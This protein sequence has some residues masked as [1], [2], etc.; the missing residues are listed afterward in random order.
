MSLHRRSIVLATALRSTFFHPHSLKNMHTSIHRPALSR[1]TAWLSGALLAGCANMSAT[2]QGTA[3]GA[4]IGAVAG[5]I[6]SAATGGDAATGAVLGGAAGALGGNIW[7]RR[8]EEK[9]RAME[10]AT[11][12]SGVQ[13]TRTADDQLKLQVPSDISFAV[14]SAAL[15]PRLRPVLDAFAHG[16]DQDRT[17][18]VRIVG[19]TDSIGSDHINDPLS[20]HRA[21]TV[22]GYL[23]DRG[24]RAERIEV[25]GRGSR[26]PVASND[27]VEDRAR[28]RRVEIFLREPRA[29]GH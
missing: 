28:N 26:E 24:I 10:R 29:S 7:S 8:L 16:L 20:L 6:I 5:V 19:H 3:Q 14:G 25:A 1:L 15:E 18:L 23:E 2:E 13:V 21:Q 11:E 9:Q 12:G 17:T 22:R 4:A 27:N